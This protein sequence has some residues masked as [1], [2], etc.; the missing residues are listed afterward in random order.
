MSLYEDI[1]V[2]PLYIG[3]VRIYDSNLDHTWDEQVGIGLIYSKIRTAVSEAL[4]S[5][6]PKTASVQGIIRH[7]HIRPNGDLCFLMWEGDVK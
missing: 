2:I 6:W 3:V 5:G 7:Y 1:S 4:Q